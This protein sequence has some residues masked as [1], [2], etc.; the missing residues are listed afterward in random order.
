[1]FMRARL[2]L[3]LR[4]KGT[5]VV[6]YIGA[7]YCAFY[8]LKNCFVSYIL[9]KIKLLYIFCNIIDILKKYY[10]NLI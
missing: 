8:G 2:F 10:Y 5:D 1:M 7:F 9:E 4:I 6:D 3:K